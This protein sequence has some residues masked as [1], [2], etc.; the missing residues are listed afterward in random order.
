[1]RTPTSYGFDAGKSLAKADL[2]RMAFIRSLRSIPE[3]AENGRNLSFQTI[4]D[5]LKKFVLARLRSLQKLP[6]TVRMFFLTPDTQYA[7]L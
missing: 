1:M 2:Y 7:A 6:W 4:R 5:E 3:M